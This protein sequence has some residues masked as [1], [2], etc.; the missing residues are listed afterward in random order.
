MCVYNIQYSLARILECSDVNYGLVIGTYTLMILWLKYSHLQ[1]HF[2][3][4]L[5]VTHKYYPCTASSSQPR[6]GGILTT[7]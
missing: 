2:V 7:L 5:I 4:E 6:S 1:I 3:A